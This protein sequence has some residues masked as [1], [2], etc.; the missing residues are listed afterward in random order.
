MSTGTQYLPLSAEDARPG[1]RARGR[2]RWV[3][4]ARVL[5]PET[6]SH[7]RIRSADMWVLSARVMADSVSFSI[8]HDWK[9][10]MIL[11]RTLTIPLL[12]LPSPGLAE[13]ADQW[14][15]QDVEQG[16][17]ADQLSTDDGGWLMACACEL[18]AVLR[19]STV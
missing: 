17:N 18:W 10:P 15:D 5:R 8:P 9:P 3:V 1:R 6:A 11:G 12:R 16:R 2:T 19:P 7:A 4:L 14:P 13:T